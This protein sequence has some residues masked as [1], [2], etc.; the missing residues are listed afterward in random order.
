[1]IWPLLLLLAPASAE[2]WYYPDDADLHA[3]L[4]DALRLG[5][6][7]LGEWENYSQSGDSAQSYVDA[8]LDRD[9]ITIRDN[10]PLSYWEG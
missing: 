5:D 7:F 10:T 3:P 2:R 1:V 9:L 8:P 4:N 6:S